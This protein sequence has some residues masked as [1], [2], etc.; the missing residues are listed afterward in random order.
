[1]STSKKETVSDVAIQTRADRAEIHNLKK[2]VEEQRLFLKAMWGIVKDKFSLDDEILG[3]M[4]CEIEK[5]EE[6]ESY[7]AEECGSCGRALQQ[8]SSFCIYCGAKVTAC[9]VL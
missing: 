1:M 9:K 4:V 7:V 2:K 5:K 6:T 8:G 3:K